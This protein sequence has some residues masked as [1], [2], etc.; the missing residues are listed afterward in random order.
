MTLTQSE[1]EQIASQAADELRGRI[2]SHPEQW[3]TRTLASVY[4]SLIGGDLELLE[5]SERD[6]ALNGDVREEILRRIA[7]YQSIGDWETERQRLARDPHAF[8]D[9]WVWMLDP[10]RIR[11]HELPVRPFHLFD[12]QR[13]FLQWLVDLYDKGRPG[14][15]LKSR[16]MGVSV[17]AAGFGVWGFLFFPSFIAGYGSYKEDYVWKLG[18]FDAIIEKCKMILDGLPPQLTPKRWDYKEG[19]I[20]NLDTGAEIK[21][22][23][24]DQLGRGGRASIFFADEF[25]YVRKQELSHKALAGTTECTIYMSTTAGPD[26]HHASMIRDRVMS[27]RVYP[28]YLDPRKLD[29]PSDVGNPAAP[30]KWKDGDP[31]DPD[32]KGMLIGVGAVGFAQEFGCDDIGALERTVIPQEWV[33]AATEI[34]LRADGRTVAGLD[35]AETRDRSVLIIRQGGRIILHRAWD[36]RTMQE[37][38]DEALPLVVQYRAEQLAYDRGGKGAEFGGIVA[39]HELRAKLPPIVGVVPTQP[40][41]SR[42]Y[43]D[44]PE[45]P[46]KHRFDYRIT[47]YWWS[48]R[49][50]F[51]RTWERHTGVCHWEDDDCIQI[52]ATSDKLIRQL[53]TRK[54]EEVARGKIG[55]ERKKNLPESPDD[56]DALVHCEVPPPMTMTSSQPSQSKPSRA[57]PKRKSAW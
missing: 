9:D 52:D 31:E 27:T 53:T 5:A 40:P 45:V 26:T 36:G 18:S 57:I 56:A 6:L 42:R 8:F 12:F 55:L 13:D 35:L 11:A 20:Q 48:L 54:W 25:A 51:R 1:I 19:H 50:R 3:S 34:Q 2:L 46:A 29:N 15:C 44:A 28:W 33:R 22:E 41:S 16:D 38:A 14:A 37:V 24:G 43:D 39:R 21:G 10:R 7:L 4:R 47:E 17:I 23:V 30:S 49:H 32:D